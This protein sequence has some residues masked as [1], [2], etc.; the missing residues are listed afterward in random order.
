MAG[1]KVADLNKT[2]EAYPSIDLPSVEEAREQAQHRAQRP[3]QHYGLAEPDSHH[4]FALGDSAQV[5]RL[6]IDPPVP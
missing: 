3:E 5:T 1:V 4:A 6:D 2:L